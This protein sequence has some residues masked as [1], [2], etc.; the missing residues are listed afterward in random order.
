MLYYYCEYI[1]R[2]APLI[3]LEHL[4]QERSSDCAGP[5]TTGDSPKTSS[6]AEI[7]FLASNPR[8][9]HSVSI[10]LTADEQDADELDAILHGKN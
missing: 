5:T 6:P 10:T 7:G 3:F 9:R 8:P 4:T 1:W 2:I